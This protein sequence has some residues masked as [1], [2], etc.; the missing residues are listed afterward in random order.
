MKKTL[1]EFYSE[2]SE[3]NFDKRK[4]QGLI[5]RANAAGYDIY[6]AY[7]E[8]GVDT[9]RH[10]W[11]SSDYKENDSD[12]KLFETTT[13][14]GKSKGG[15]NF[16]K[17]QSY[18]AECAIF[19]FC[20]LNTL[21]SDEILRGRKIQSVR[22][23]AERHAIADYDR[24]I[25]MQGYYDK[26]QLLADENKAEIAKLNDEINAIFGQPGS[27]ILRAEKEKRITELGG[28][29]LI[30]PDWQKKALEFTHRDAY[31]IHKQDLAEKALLSE[32]E[33]AD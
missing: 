26:W 20:P 27:R 33:M 21:L 22:D 17:G 25:E 16:K 5:K 24:A 32:L 15:G 30:L 3:M 6:Y 11:K 13:L 29:F 19:I 9:W 1:F 8:D 12:V 31:I 28:S 18:T 2:L 4:V 10:G 7:H 23:A 14:I